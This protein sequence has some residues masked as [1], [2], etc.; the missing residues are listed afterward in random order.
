MSVLALVASAVLLIVFIAGVG[1]GVRLS[2]WAMGSQAADIFE[3]AGV[4]L[5][6]KS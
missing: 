4:S 2:Q 6:G 1:A 3:Q 5:D